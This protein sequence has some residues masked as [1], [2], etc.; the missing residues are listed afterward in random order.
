M[1]TWERVGMAAINKGSDKG[2]CVNKSKY[3]Q[4]KTGL[5]NELG[6][7]CLGP[8]EVAGP[9]GSFKTDFDAVP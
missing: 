5:D 4:T 7:R 9:R 8:A 3:R 1:D 6:P 2:E